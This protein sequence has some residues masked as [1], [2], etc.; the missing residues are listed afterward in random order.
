MARH[1]KNSWKDPDRLIETCVRE[2]ERA[3][4][5]AFR[6]YHQKVDSF[7]E[8]WGIENMTIQVTLRDCYFYYNPKNETLT[9][10][11]TCEPAKDEPDIIVTA[12]F[13][14]F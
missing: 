3:V 4:K 7:Y 2:T 8:K 9:H 1:K 5:L 6:D 14:D 10:F 12:V 13:G 11:C